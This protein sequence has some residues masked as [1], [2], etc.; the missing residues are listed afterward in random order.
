MPDPYREKPAGYPQNAPF[1]PGVIQITCD[2]QHDP[3][4]EHIGPVEYYPT[5][6][7]DT[8]YYP[9]Y[10]QPGYQSPY[11]MVQFT[12]PAYGKLIYVECRAWAKNIE[13]DRYNQK[14]MTVFELFIEKQT[15]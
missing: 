9:F 5:N 15:W 11:V 14:G 10:N 6:T 3:D 2:G 1:I 8:K 13:H 12:N 4:K 7:I